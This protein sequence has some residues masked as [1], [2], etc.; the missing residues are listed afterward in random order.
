LKPPTHT[1]MKQI[2][3]IAL[4]C[5]TMLML[6][7]QLLKNHR[8]PNTL[9]SPPFSRVQWPLPFPLKRPPPT[10]GS[11]PCLID[12]LH[13]SSPGL[14]MILRLWSR[15]NVQMEHVDGHSALMWKMGTPQNLLFSSLFISEQI[16]GSSIHWRRVWTASTQWKE[17]FNVN[18]IHL[19]CNKV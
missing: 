9:L 5:L 1:Y 15:V 14:H 6:N 19:F 17:D 18:M 3:L 12:L 7:K 4:K 2:H 13:K 16:D 8:N 11:C 10:W